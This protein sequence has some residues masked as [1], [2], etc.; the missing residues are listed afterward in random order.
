M[1]LSF[2]LSG[3]LLG[4][5]GT[6][7][8]PA[9]NHL[10]AAERAD[11]WRLL[12]DG[13]TSTGWRG[14]HQTGFPSKGWDVKDGCLHHAARAGGG[15]LVTDGLFEDYDFR[16][17]WKIDAGGNSGVKYFI[18]ED[19]SGAIGHE[20]QLMGSR[21]PA[22]ALV[23]LKH[24]TASFYDVLPPATNALPRSPGEWNESRILVQGNH[25]EHWL[26]GVQ[27]LTYELGSDAVKAGIAASKFKTVP[28]FGTHF[29]HRLLLQDHGG[30]VA[31]RNLKL[32]VLP[33]ETR[34]AA[35]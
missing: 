4:L 17:E 2:L 33:A 27:V 21:T 28:G 9:V 6:A 22:E 11:G 16:F 25:V 23:D 1:R 15:D 7:A 29:A 32:R 12:F 30:D 13:T 5:S 35:H 3:M 19:R 14:F 26:N 24:A 18:T 10:T 34:H 20:Y 8:E 31:F